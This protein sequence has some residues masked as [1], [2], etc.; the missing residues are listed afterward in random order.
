MNKQRLVIKIGSNTLL[1]DGSLQTSYFE[2][3]FTVLKKLRD[4][5]YAPILVLSGAVA[6]GKLLTGLGTKQSRAAVG[7]MQVFHLAQTAAAHA[8]IP[9]AA[10]LLSREDIVHRSRY[11]TLRQTLT[12]L[13]AA[14]VVPIIN[15][16]DATTVAGA[17]AFVDNDQLA[18]IVAMM[19]EADA[20]F[21]LTGVEGVFT[22][23]PLRNERAALILEIPEINVELLRR[24]AHGKTPG[25]R[26]GMERKLWAA[27]IATAS[28]IPTH[29][30]QGARP[31]LLTETLLEGKP[32]GTRCL[33]KKEGRREF[34]LKDR[35]ILSAHNSGASIRLDAG[36]ARAIKE[37]KSLLAVGVKWVC[38][39]FHE[40]E[41][42]E[43]LDEESEV[44]ALGLP[45]LSS[46]KL[47]TL[48]RA[49]GKPYNVEI[50]HADNIRLLI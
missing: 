37:R 8:G 32:Q 27:R 23:N 48:V 31:E 10:L 16:N 22:E 9:L 6:A 15:E 29:I 47:T 28:G 33:A 43:L 12:D 11:E 36:A 2:R 30:M 19:V 20:L 18:T 26:G 45:S 5:G 7:Q 35:W 14:G 13:L 4:V 40:K 39:N 17:T 50:M 38:G 34:S 25:G 49:E 3:L 44:I 24:L 21:L 1:P 42:V 46:R 41:S